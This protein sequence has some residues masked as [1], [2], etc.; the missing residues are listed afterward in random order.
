M[1]DTPP[2]QQQTIAGLVWSE[3]EEDWPPVKSKGMGSGWE[4]DAPDKK[5]DKKQHK[6]YSRLGSEEAGTRKMATAHTASHSA[7]LG[8]GAGYSVVGRGT[9]RR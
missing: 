1:V 8:R 5:E 9:E 2:T 6:V 7:T 4:A 3:G